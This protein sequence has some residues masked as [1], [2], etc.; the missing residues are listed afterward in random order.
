LAGSVSTF[1][2]V[3]AGKGFGKSAADAAAVKAHSTTGAARTPELTTLR[4]R[5]RHS[6][7]FCFAAVRL[8]YGECT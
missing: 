1:G 5:I 2:I 8:L 3:S 4:N 6:P 7:A